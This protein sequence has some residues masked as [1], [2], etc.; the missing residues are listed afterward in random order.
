LGASL[1]PLLFMAL[2]AAACVIPIAV[3]LTQQP[4]EKD[5]PH[6]PHLSS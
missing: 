5:L 6:G 4:A 3:D 1:S 2:L